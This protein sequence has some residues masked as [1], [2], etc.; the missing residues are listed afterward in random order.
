MFINIIEHI[1]RLCY[2][3]FIKENE[4]AERIDIMAKETQKAK[5]E[6]LENE[7][8]A[9][10]KVIA[11]QND[12]INKIQA[13]ADES[14]S[15]SPYKKQ[16]EDKINMLEMKLKS[17]QAGKEHAEKMAK[18]KD[19]RLQEALKGNE[20]AKHYKKL[21]RKAK[22]TDAEIQAIKMVRLQGKSYREIAKQFD[23]S[24]GIVHKLINE[25]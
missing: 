13:A 17:A 7:L 19:E 18:A 5:I 23:C 24:V 6:R 22:F 8:L 16:L 4:H 21:G 3:M 25:H 14:F 12:Y 10:H 2:N 15:N 1:P 9:A 11:E 20:N